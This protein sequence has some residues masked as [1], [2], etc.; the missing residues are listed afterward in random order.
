MDCLNNAHDW[1][2][3]GNVIHTKGYP[4][5]Q[6][7]NRLIRN[8]GFHLPQIIGEFNQIDNLNK[9]QKYYE[10]G[11]IAGKVTLDIFKV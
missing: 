8:I 9:E 3:I 5:D 10:A 2:D 11:Q 4:G 6:I 7:R 1:D